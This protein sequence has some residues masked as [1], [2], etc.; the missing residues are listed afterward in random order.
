[1]KKIAIVTD[2]STGTALRK[3]LGN[4]KS[5]ATV[6]GISK[7]IKILSGVRPFKVFAVKRLYNGVF[8]ALSEHVLLILFVQHL[9][10]RLGDV[11]EV[12]RN[13][14]VGLG[15]TDVGENR[16]QE[17][18]AKRDVVT[19]AEWHFIGRRRPRRKNPRPAF[20]RRIGLCLS[21]AF[22]FCISVFFARNVACMQGLVR[23]VAIRLFKVGRQ[24][25]CRDQDSSG[26]VCK[27]DRRARR[28]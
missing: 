27:C 28:D 10:A 17:Y 23:Y 12:A 8:V 24:A 13:A 4:M 15:V 21:C 1:M 2:R 7:P 19:G 22:V 26:G 18:L 14:I 5:S 9:G 3:P 11:D 16:V 6:S 20:L 25:R